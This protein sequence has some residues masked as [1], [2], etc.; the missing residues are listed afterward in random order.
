MSDIAVQMYGGRPLANTLSEKLSMTH[1]CQLMFVGHRLQTMGPLANT[2]SDD[3]S[4]PRRALPACLPNFCWTS[5]ED[6][7]GTGS[8]FDPMLD[9]TIT[10][11]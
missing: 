11:R 9:E 8:V 3:F 10:Y 6:T 2:T 5:D 4:S 1:P 7:S